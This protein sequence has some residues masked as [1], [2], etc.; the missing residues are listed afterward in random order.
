MNFKLALFCAGICSA[1]SLGAVS[2]AYAQAP[3]QGVNGKVTNNSGTTLIVIWHKA[4]NY[5]HTDDQMIQTNQL[6][7]GKTGANVGYKTGDYW[8]LQVTNGTA[9]AQSPYYGAGSANFV[10]TVTAGPNPTPSQTP[11]VVTCK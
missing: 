7:S 2:H 8:S 9:S 6:E 10:C 3:I 5:E 11:L 4:S 1:V